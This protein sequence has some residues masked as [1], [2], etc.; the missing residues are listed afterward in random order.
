MWLCHGTQNPGCPGCWASGGKGKVL[1]PLHLG[2]GPEPSRLGV[3]RAP[4]GPPWAWH[5]PDS[6]GAGCLLRSTQTQPGV[7]LPGALPATQAHICLSL[8]Y[9]PD[10]Y[11]RPLLPDTTASAHTAFQGLLQACRLTMLSHR[12][13]SPR[14]LTAVPPPLSTSSLQRGSPSLF[15]AFLPLLPWSHPVPPGFV[16]LSGLLQAEA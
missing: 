7:W 1:V 6:A 12:P 10:I 14:P 5:R 9:S 4:S 3:T 11:Q 2:C 16:L 8:T 15:H 13:S